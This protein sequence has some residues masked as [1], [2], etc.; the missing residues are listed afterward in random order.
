M[1]TN[2][3][4]FS[5]GILFHDITVLATVKNCIF[6]TDTQ[7]LLELYL[8]LKKNDGELLDRFPNV[9]EFVDSMKEDRMKLCSAVQ[10][11]VNQNPLL[12][13]Y[14][15][16]VMNPIGFDNPFLYTDAVYR[17][18]YYQELDTLKVDPIPT[19]IGNLFNISI[20]LDQFKKLYLIDE[21][22]SEHMRTYMT[23]FFRG[24]GK[25]EL[26]EGSIEEA[27]NELPEVNF[28]VLENAE[29]VTYLMKPR[30]NRAEVLIPGFR[31][32]LLNADDL[33]EQVPVLALPEGMDNYG[34]DFNLSINSIAVPI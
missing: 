2:F 25:I 4:M 32:N 10:M 33:E 28:Y 29:M 23:S 17:R 18:L 12:D 5:P 34:N 15:W 1:D 22:Y 30:I 26:L 8:L 20:K 14:N 21:H 11:K 7:V 3:N 13:F 16:D 19:L 24:N 6:N 27:I 9:V 31:S